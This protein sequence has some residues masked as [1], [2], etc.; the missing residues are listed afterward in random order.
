MGDD[1]R[2]IVEPGRTVKFCE[3]GG[4]RTSDLSEEMILVFKK[5]KRFNGR[6]VKFI[7]APGLGRP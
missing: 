1:E 5:G 4:I 6:G 3:K 2:W 7:Y